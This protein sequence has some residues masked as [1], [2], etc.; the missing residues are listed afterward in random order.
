MYVHIWQIPVCFGKARGSN[1]DPGKLRRRVHLLSIPTASVPELGRQ[2]KLQKH[3]GNASA[4][5]SEAP[6]N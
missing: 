2:P 6:A 3:L 5:V 1:S 4:S